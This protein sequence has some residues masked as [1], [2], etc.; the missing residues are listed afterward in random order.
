MKFV[1]EFYVNSV[2]AAAAAVLLFCHAEM[3]TKRTAQKHE[4]EVELAI[5][6]CFC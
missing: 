1:A 5:Y 2:L 4:V 6:T 3:R